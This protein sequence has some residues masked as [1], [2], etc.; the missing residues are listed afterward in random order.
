MQIKSKMPQSCANQR[1]D[2]EKLDNINHDSRN[3]EG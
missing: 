1:V 3:L 2:I